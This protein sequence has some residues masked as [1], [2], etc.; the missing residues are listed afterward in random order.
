MKIGMSNGPPMNRI[1]APQP[2]PASGKQ[3]YATWAEASAAVREMRKQPI[4][5]K[6]LRHLNVF[7]CRE[8]G[9]FHVGHSHKT[10]RANARARQAEQPAPGPQPTPMTAAQAARQAKPEA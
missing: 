10:D 7:Q 3:Q 8:C 4:G 1:P 6:D 9:K 2:C 5:K